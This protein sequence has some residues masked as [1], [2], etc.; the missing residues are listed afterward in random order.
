MGGFTENNHQ[1]KTLVT[2]GQVPTVPTPPTATPDD[3]GDWN[4]ATDLLIGQYCINAIDGLEFIRDGNTTIQSRRINEEKREELEINAGAATINIFQSDVLYATMVEA[5]TFSESN[6]RVF[7]DV[8]LELQGDYV[9]TFPT[10]WEAVGG[11]TYDGTASKINYIYIRCLNSTTPHVIYEIK[12]VG[13]GGGGGTPATPLTSMQ[14]NDGSAFGGSNQLY[15]KATGNHGINTSPG[16][17]KMEI[18]SDDNAYSTI[19]TEFTN[20]SDGANIKIYADGRIV[21]SPVSTVTSRPTIGL[22]DLGTGFFKSIATD[23]VAATWRGSIIWKGLSIY[24]RSTTISAWHLKNQSRSSTNP[25]Y[26]FGNNLDTG[27][28]GANGTHQ[29]SGISNSIETLRM[30]Q[31]K[32]IFRPGVDPQQYADNAAAVTAGEIIG[33]SYR[34]TGTDN[35]GIVHS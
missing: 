31:G 3:V 18:Q 28:G 30:D 4:N 6:L 22:D 29:L 1:V 24:L 15:N 32:V 2:P 9:P 17:A 12:R 10:S 27:I 7:K 20:P 34:I 21:A 5:T 26:V 25:V 23:E 33:T 11:L 19:V 13:E 14:Y 35:M 16:V 8:V